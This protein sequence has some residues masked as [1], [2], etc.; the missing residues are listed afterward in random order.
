MELRYLRYFVAVAEA[1][2]FT[3]AAEK[4][5]ISQPPLSQQIKKFEQEIGTPLFKRL[6]RGVEMTE[7]GK[8]LYKD[9]RQILQQT[10]MALDKAK[11]I[12]RGEKGSF[13][14]GFS[15]SAS[16]HPAVLALLHAYQHRY[17]NVLVIPQED[18][19]PTLLAELHDRNIDLVFLRLP[20]NVGDDVNGEILAEESMQ[21]VL[22]ANHAL[23]RKKRIQLSELHQE[24]L[25]IFPRDVCPGLHDMI[26]R[27]CYLS[28]YGP[29]LSQFAPQLP[30]TIG[31]VAAGFGVTI[32]PASLSCIKADN[33][34]YHEI[35]SP[36]I[37]TQ[38]AVIWRKHERSAAVQNMVA[39][40]REQLQHR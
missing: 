9:A 13:N 14:V 19:S 27:S 12:A 1:R 8:A 4:L 37:T 16:F 38:I 31:M 21:L 18:N 23:G 7:A 22:P 17:P 34:T 25:I 10:D 5:G 15:S 2:H 11:S 33:V 20:C 32:I 3:R 40:L 29:K 39:L 30:A 26:I 36:H 6:T 24:P 28:G 35:D